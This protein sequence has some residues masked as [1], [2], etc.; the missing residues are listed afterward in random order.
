M[1][2][3]RFAEVEP[4]ADAVMYEGYVLYPYRASA[5]KNQFRWQF[6]VVAPREYSESS[7]TDSWHTQTE[8]VL[9]SLGTPRLTVRVRCLQLQRR[10]LE[11]PSGTDEW[12]GCER[13]A[14][15]GRE[16]QA[17]DEAVPQDVTVADVAIDDHSKRC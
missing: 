4:I 15:D 9:E 2:A 11:R 7:G 14:V 8:C 17:W 6:G 16:M 12:L 10:T 13:L 5:I 1:S 3:S